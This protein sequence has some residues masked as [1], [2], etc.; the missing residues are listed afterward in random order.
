MRL[1]IM[2]LNLGQGAHKGKWF[3]L[4]DIIRNQQPDALLFQE[5]RDWGPNH[6]YTRLAT[7]E[8]DLNMR[9]W[10]GRSRYHLPT[11]I[12]VT[13]HLAQLWRGIEDYYYED[14][15]HGYCSLRLAIGLPLPLILTSV[16]L[17][18]YSTDRAAQEAQLVLSRSSG[19][20][21]ISIIGGD[22]NHA[23][24]GDPEPDWTQL[25]NYNRASRTLPTSPG[26]PTVSN[27][28]VGEVFRQGGFRDTIATIAHRTHNPALR[29]PT[30]HNGR[31][32]V[33]Q[34]QL[35]PAVAPALLDAWHVP[36]APW[37]DHDGV[38]A[39]IDTELINP[40]LA[41]QWQ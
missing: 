36:T 19:K 16:H 5:A 21:G 8:H 38:V 37:T 6:D 26:A 14:V 24:L 29:Q 13:H 15:Q 7:A 27:T 35:A 25:P 3:G 40:D 31:I 9:G 22:L 23:P 32:R 10:I 2:T 34:I 12:L 4:T 11:G 33:D 41:R 30:G 1:R 18:P 39:D 20:G 17:T 28:L